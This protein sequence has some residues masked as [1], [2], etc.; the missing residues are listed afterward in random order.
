MHI[1]ICDDNIAERKQSERLLKRE[2]DKLISSGEPM[3]I[4]SYGNAEA[5]LRTPM[6]YDAFII[7]IRNT[8]GL[9][10]AM[11]LSS[12][13]KKGVTSP[14]CVIYPREDKN[15]F[16]KSDTVY[17]PETLFLGK[18]LRPEEL[19]ES[20]LKFKRISLDTVPSIELR[21][22]YETNYVSESEIIF[23]R[24]EGPKAR[25]TLADGREL[26]INSDAYT[27]F[28][29]ITKE[30][31]M[32]VMPTINILINIDYIDH[33]RLGRIHL[34]NGKSFRCDRSV[35]RYINAYKKGEL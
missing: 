11:V 20:I 9:N 1:A 29:E 10:S 19:H 7:D 6:Q 32:F 35:L 30:H 24:T 5:L 34:T 25:V 33:I 16:D 8:E 17:P 21:G 13:R 2:A 4:D 31:N 3:Y 12:L 18:P 27:L 28:E 14:I 15:F 22:E 23:A 26:I